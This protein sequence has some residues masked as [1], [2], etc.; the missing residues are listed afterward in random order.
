MKASLIIHDL[1]KLSHYQKVLFN[2]EI[3]GYTDNSNNNS[4]HYK[5]KGLLSQIPHLRLLKGALVINST[6]INKIKLLLRKYGI[7]YEIY[8]ILIKESKL[9]KV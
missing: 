5:R 7:K 4:Y 2:R 1:S 8:D 3:Y 9:K 6:D